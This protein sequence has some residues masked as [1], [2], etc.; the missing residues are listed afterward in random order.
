MT[1]QRASWPNAALHVGGSP[2]IGTPYKFRIGIII[3]QR[4]EAVERY[5]QAVEMARVLLMPGTISSCC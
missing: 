5:R 1:V 4:D 3:G 2:N